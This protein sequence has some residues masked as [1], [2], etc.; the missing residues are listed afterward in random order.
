MLSN[1]SMPCG[2]EW[3]SGITACG[4]KRSITA[5][6]RLVER[7]GPADLLEPAR[8][9]PHGSRTDRRVGW[10]ASFADLYCRCRH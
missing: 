9:G 3:F 8:A 1:D 6:T 2:P 5:V 4:P 7:F 10:F